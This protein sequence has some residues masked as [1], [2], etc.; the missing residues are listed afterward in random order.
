VLVIDGDEKSRETYAQTLRREGYGVLVAH[1]GVEGLKVA[2]EAKP[3]VVLLDLQLAGASGLEVLERLPSV[4]PRIVPIV[5]SGNATVETAVAA[6]KRGAFEFFG[7]PQD[8]AKIAD[9]VRRALAKWEAQ[10]KDGRGAENASAAA[11]QSRP[12]REPDV[13]LKSLEALRDGYALGLTPGALLEE[14]KSLE[15]EARRLAESL[16][17][18]KTREKLIADLVADLRLVDEIL[19]RHEF[20][21]NALIQIL[22]DVQQRKR[23][24]PR[25]VILWIARRL[26]VPISRIYEIANFYEVFSLTPQGAHTI[27]VCLGTACHV[28]G[29]PQLLSQISTVLGI[30]AGETDRKGVFTL[31]SVHCLGCCALAPVVTIDGNFYGNPDINQLREIFKSCEAEVEASCQG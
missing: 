4:D 28:R 13:I 24:L 27:Q 11:R 1:D 9:A 20:K 8:A 2:G 25:H 17:Q 7:K 31:K 22:I 5:V 16:G 26:E 14:M 3:K 23:W 29:G 18:N 30:K 19:A 15:D 10:A 12:V 6:M 21:K